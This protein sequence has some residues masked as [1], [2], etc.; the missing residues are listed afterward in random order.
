MTTPRKNWNSMVKRL[1]A[2]GWTRIGSGVLSAY[3]H[4]D[5]GK[6]VPMNIDPTTEDHFW[7][8]Y[9]NTGTPS[10]TTTPLGDKKEKI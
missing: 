1:K 2:A 3:T 5:G 6:F 10:T 9:L 8:A 7:R 4:P